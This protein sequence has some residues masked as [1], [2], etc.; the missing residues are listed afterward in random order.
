MKHHSTILPIIITLLLLCCISCKTTEENYRAAYQQA[1]LTKESKAASSDVESIIPQQRI[2]TVTETDSNQI[3]T[4]LEF[5]VV[6]GGARSELHTYNV[7]VAE[8]TQLFNA[9]SF[10]DR[11]IAQQQTQSYVLRNNHN[12]YFTIIQGFDTKTEAI[13]Y[14]NNLDIKLPIPKAWILK[15]IN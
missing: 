15:S 10:R 14:I 12:K 8:F 7:V 4:K 9:K 2:H 11:L 13:E 5:V 6:V 1:I 3:V